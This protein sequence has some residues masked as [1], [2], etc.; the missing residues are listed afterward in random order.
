MKCKYVLHSLPDY[1]RGS[2]D[3]DESDIIADHLLKCSKCS[4]EKERLTRLFENI[5][6]Q[7]S[8]TPSVMYWNN[9]LPRIHSQIENKSSGILS[10]RLIYLCTPLAAFLLIII[11]AFYFL[12]PVTDDN[13]SSFKSSVAQL[14]RDELQ[15]YIGQE[16]IIGLH[17]PYDSTSGIIFSGDDKTVLRELL[18]QD[19]PTY[20]LS[21]PDQ[22]IDF[23]NLSDQDVEYLVPIM[24]RNLGRSKSLN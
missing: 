16:V 20:L 12:M 1:V 23:S 21:E 22:G 4:G 9:L 6:D 17:E 8:W 13:S 2:V 10:E 14:S 5:Q 15:E 11:L 18:K 19:N 7:R 24:E 3:K